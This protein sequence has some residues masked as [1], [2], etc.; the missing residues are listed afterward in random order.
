MLVSHFFYSQEQKT[1]SRSKLS[2]TT[3]KKWAGMCLLFCVLISLVIGGTAAVTYFLTLEAEPPTTTTS[4]ST[5]T[6]TT[7]AS[8]TLPTVM[9]ST[10]PELQILYREQVWNE[11]KYFDKTFEEYK[12]GFQS[13]GQN[14]IL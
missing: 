2:S 6:P 1:H 9:S 5:S 4:T 10:G 12:H 14:D 11:A 8:T 7:T 13:R 3:C